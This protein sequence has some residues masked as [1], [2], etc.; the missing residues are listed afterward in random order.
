MDSCKPKGGDDFVEG[1]DGA[2]VRPRPSVSHPLDDLTQSGMIG[3]D[4]EVDRQAITESPGI[5]IN[6]HAKRFVARSIKLE[7]LKECL[8]RGSSRLCRVTSIME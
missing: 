2:D 3:F 1:R 6:L 5:A 8:E 7:W 4:N